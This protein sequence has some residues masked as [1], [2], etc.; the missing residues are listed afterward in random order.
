M[1]HI[2]GGPLIKREKGVGVLSLRACDT[3]TIKYDGKIYLS[4]CFYWYF[5]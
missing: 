2:R 4:C 3:I 1:H 5:L